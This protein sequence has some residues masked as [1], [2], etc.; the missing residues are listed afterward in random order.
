[1]TVQSILFIVAEQGDQSG[2]CGILPERTDLVGR[3]D[4]CEE[5]TTTLTSN[6]VVELV[7]PPGHGKTS[8]VVEVAYRM[9][10]KGLRVA[11]VNP[12]GVT[13]VEDLASI[14]IEAL[15]A[16][17]GEDT[18]KEL[19]R[20]IR[21]LKLKSLVVIIE[22]IDNLLYIEN[23]ENQ[24]RNEKHH[25][26][27]DSEV[28]CAKTRGKYKKD[29]FLTFLEDIGQ[30]STTHLLL[31][32][33]DS[34]DFLSF[35]I[36][37]IDLPPLNE[38]DSVTLFRTRDQTLLAD[39]LVKA[40]VPFC[41]GI[42]LIICTVLSILKK[43]NPHN[44]ARRLSTSSPRSFIRSLSPANLAQ[45][46]RI[47]QCLQ[48]CFNRLSQENQ[49]V[50]VMISTFPH[51]FT[52]EQFLG[53][54]QSSPELDLQMCLDC[55]KYSSLL[56]FE[57]VTSRYSLHPFIRK[58]FSVKPKHKDAKSVFIL[59]YSDLAVTLCEEFLS[60]RS[61]SAI[62]RY[63]DEKENIREAM[64]WCGDDHPELDQ[65]TREQCI[66]AFSKSAVFL[67]KMMR[68]QEFESLFCK[69]ARQCRY[70]IKLYSACLTS[71]GMKVVLSCTCTPYICPRALFRAKKILSHAN[72]FQSTHTAVDDASRAHC[73]SKLGFCFVREG[74]C[75]DGYA[76]LNDALELRR[77]QAESSSENKEKVMLAACFNDLA[78][79]C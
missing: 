26:E 77:K 43:E 20:R 46:R 64:T 37:L 73:L 53:V 65:T 21:T 2:H 13:C 8:V 50:L 35:P 38:K 6:K 25:E 17:P 14:I 34:I 9:I 16:V 48:V 18:I 29:D 5:I 51:R 67:A 59:Y 24:I 7:A 10:E 36:T 31:T 62:E 44:L 58:F 70:D 52:Q 76:L 74:S 42:P 63:R 49:D 15:D 27:L 41:G 28:H 47:D 69:L 3:D 72:Q 79:S 1:M 32:S 40:L 22:N 57:K 54:F 39:D 55:L 78:G 71:M 12:R 66:D 75:E 30:S 19:L 23:L 11:Y 61:K 56:R 33:R 45:V 60:N 68:K 4:I